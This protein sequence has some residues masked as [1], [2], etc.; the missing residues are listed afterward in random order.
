MP[1]AF[2]W[3]CWP[4]TVQWA[5]SLKNLRKNCIFITDFISKKPV[6]L[7]L[8]CRKIPAKARAWIQ[9]RGHL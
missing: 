2:M 8:Q 5:K 3:L 1:V 7:L 6:V 4:R 9:A